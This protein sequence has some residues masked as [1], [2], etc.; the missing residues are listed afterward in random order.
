MSAITC[1]L[2]SRAAQEKLRVC[3]PYSSGAVKNLA[4]SD[5]DAVTKLHKSHSETIFKN[6]KPAARNWLPEYQPEN[7]MPPSMN[8]TNKTLSSRG[9][10]MSM[11][12]LLKKQIT[13]RKVKIVCTMGP[14][15]WDEETL[16]K[17]LDAG[18]NIARFNFSHGSHEAHLEVLERYRK[19]LG[20]KQSTAACLMD[21]KGPEIRTAMLKDHASI[22]LEKGEEIVVE[23]VGDRYTEFEGY[24]DERGTRIGLS[25]AQL[26]Q[27]VK[28]GQRILIADGS[29]V[30]QVLEILSETEL[31][32]RVLNSKELGERKNCNLPGVHVEIP[33]LTTK[34]IDDVQNFCAKHKMDY[35]A[36]S[37]VQSGADVDFIRKTLDD[38][39]G[40]H[41]AIISKIENEAGLENIDEII[42]KSD[43]IMVARGDL[44]MEIPSEKVSLAQKMIITKCNI[45]GVFVITATQM[46]ES[47]CSN[48]LPTRAEMTDVANAVFDG[49]DCVM[50]SGETANG[51]FPDAA[52]R[53]MAHIVANAEL[54]NN[55]YAIYSFIR[56]FTPKPFSPEESFASNA[57]KAAIECKA[58]LCIVVTTDGVKSNFVSKYRPSVPIVV[59]TNTDWVLKQANGRFG[60]YACLLDNMSPILDPNSMLSGGTIQKGIQFAKA[61]KLLPDGQS[62]VVVIGEDSTGSIAISFCST[63]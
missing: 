5:F 26:C 34:D 18:M 22:V 48:P 45:A 19:V 14:K 42:A 56:D 40:Q 54:V 61:Q 43:G 31:K 6:D 55:Y 29:I 7:V 51:A 28:V 25:Y 13:K 23:A 47:M 16:G 3:Y 49:T 52:V 4:P 2:G 12:S 37:F 46:L 11:D 33:V 32:G 58:S 53:T 30:I 50:L 17:L 59:L 60:Q 27:S 8:T 57:A 38:A 41:V 35:I 21:T 39:G 15:C 1:L 10:R 36:A 20:E 44:G 24:K 63:T 62:E 9:T